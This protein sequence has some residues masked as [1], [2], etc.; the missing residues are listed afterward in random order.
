ML[1]FYSF[2]LLISFPKNFDDCV[3][4]TDINVGGIP[5]VFCIILQMTGLESNLMLNGSF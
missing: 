3:D 4:G 2:F 5:T 1:K